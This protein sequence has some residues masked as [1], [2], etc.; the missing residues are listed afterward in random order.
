MECPRCFL[1]MQLS[2]KNNEE[3]CECPGCE[4]LWLDAEIIGNIFDLSMEKECDC[5]MNSV[6]QPVTKIFQTKRIITFIRNHL[7]KTRILM[8]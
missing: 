8:K 3:V 5:N 7:L 1:E 2:V 4:G 6:E